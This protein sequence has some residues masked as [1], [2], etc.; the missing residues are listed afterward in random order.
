MVKTI[1]LAWIFICLAIVGC[2][3]NPVQKNNVDRYELYNPNCARF[4]QHIP[5]PDR[6]NSAD[7][8]E[9]MD[10]SNLCKKIVAQLNNSKSEHFNNLNKLN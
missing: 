10:I 4:A 5:I 1:G 7:Y 8:Q 2:S 6:L 9:R 3:T